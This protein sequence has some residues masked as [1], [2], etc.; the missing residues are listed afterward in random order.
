MCFSDNG[1]ITS[2]FSDECNKP[3]GTMVLSGV[4]AGLCRGHR[5]G[6]QTPRALGRQ[7]DT[8]WAAVPYL[9]SMGVCVVVVE[10]GHQAHS[11]KLLPQCLLE[12]LPQL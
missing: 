11:A 2:A 12:P 4:I 6:A 5:I 9:I 3:N 10:R 1:R 8:C 7:Q